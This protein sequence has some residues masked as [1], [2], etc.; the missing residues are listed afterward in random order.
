MDIAIREAMES[1]YVSSIRQMMNQTNQPFYRKIEKISKKL[2]SE[3]DIIRNY[4]PEEIKVEERVSPRRIL[5]DN[6]VF[7][8]GM[9]NEVTLNKV[10][11]ELR[12]HNS[13]NLTLKLNSVNSKE[14]RLERLLSEEKF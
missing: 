14:N 4:K 2:K 3:V 5:T 12:D 11:A 13:I 1:N 10:I 7:L 9:L 8:Q 6:V